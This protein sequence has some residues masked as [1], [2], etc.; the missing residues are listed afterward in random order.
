MKIGCI[1]IT[2]KIGEKILETFNSIYNQVDKV[3]FVDNDSNTDTKNILSELNNKYKNC[4]VIFNEKNE[5]IAKALNIGIKKLLLDDIDF[6]LTLDHDSIASQNMINEMEC[7]YNK[8]KDKEK[9]GILSPA[10][11]DI[12]KEDYLTDVNS[13]EY[14]IIKEPIQSGSLIDVNIFNEVGLYNEDLFIYYVDTELCYR[15]NL[16]GYKNIQCN[17]AI[18]CHEEG[19][20]SCH[21]VLGKKIYY[22]NYSDLAIYYRARNG[23]YMKKKYKLYFSS[24]H[25]IYKDIIKIILCD[26]KPYNKLLV[27][28]HGIFEGMKLTR[29]KEL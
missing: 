25:V 2:Y 26:K 3:I 27:H 7:I 14:Q 17:K 18:M 19:K 6:I 28:F 5:G 21:S 10:I 29:R 4:D 20:K 15:S 22:N 13:D 16:N 1:I 11:Y 24:K 12:N 9:I 23:V 8:L